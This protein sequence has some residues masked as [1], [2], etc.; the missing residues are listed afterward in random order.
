M[1]ES[2]DDDVAD[3]ALADPTVGPPG[4]LETMSLYDSLL[5][6]VA[7][8]SSGVGIEDVVGIANLRINAEVGPQGKFIL[9]QEIG[10]GAM[11]RVYR[12]LDRYLLRDVAIKFILRPEGMNHDDFMALFWQ[13]AH[14]IAQLDQ[15]DNI[16]RILDVDRAG[17]PPFIVMEYLDGQ[18]LEAMLQSGPLDVRTA[19]HIMIAVA[20]G[21]GEAH[22]KGVCHR[23]LKPSNIF[24]QKAGRVKLLD[25]G[26]ARIRN[27]MFDVAL[28]GG[29]LV[30]PR[31]VP[32]L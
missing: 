1:G 24:V 21:L 12:A 19:L 7:A 25:F 5:R 20:C 3:G 30:A 18:S 23:D 22:A 8:S 13:E 15:H 32:R 26:L 9:Q 28:S 29:E 11:G 4:E 10:S 17:Y 31:A 6:G 27:Q 2:G 16:V 14:I